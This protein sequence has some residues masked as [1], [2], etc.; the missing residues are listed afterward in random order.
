MKKDFYA[1]MIEKYNTSASLI[2]RTRR[3]IGLP[4]GVDLNKDQ[5]K[6]LEAAIKLR[7]NLGNIPKKERIRIVKKELAEKGY[8][9]AKLISRLFNGRNV[10]TSVIVLEKEIGFDLYDDEIKLLRH[11]KSEDSKSSEDN[12]YKNIKVYRSL[13]AQFEEWKKERQSKPAKNGDTLNHGRNGGHRI[14]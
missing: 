11:G 4:A 8:V 2:S 13:T 5:F 6:K 14:C 9:E 1:R 10:G 7:K 3:E 12:K